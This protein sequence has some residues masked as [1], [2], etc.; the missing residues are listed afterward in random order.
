MSRFKNKKLSI[1][2]KNFSGGGGGW[3]WG[4]L[5]NGSGLSLVRLLSLKVC[6][7]GI[8]AKRLISSYSQVF[9]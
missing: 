8:L 9:M 3:G 7:F 6:I 4:K 1:A 5:A 2:E